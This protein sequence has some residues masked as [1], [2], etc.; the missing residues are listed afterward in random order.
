[1]WHKLIAYCHLT[2]TVTV[3]R[4]GPDYR[5]I[6]DDVDTGEYSTRPLAAIDDKIALGLA[7]VFCALVT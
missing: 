5:L 6:Y 3:E 7:A 2:K 4:N 1:M